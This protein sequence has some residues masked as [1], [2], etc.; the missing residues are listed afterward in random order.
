MNTSAP[1]VAVS[2]GNFPSGSDPTYWTG[3]GVSGGH[4]YIAVSHS[5]DDLLGVEDDLSWHS[6]IGVKSATTLYGFADGE[7]IGS[8]SLTGG[9]GTYLSIGNYMATSNSFE[10][11]GDIAEVIVFNYQLNPSDRTVVQNYLVDK[12]PELDGLPFLINNDDERIN[13]QGGEN[14]EFEN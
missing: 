8:S 10:W 7:S 2:F 14:L 13:T 6:T 5:F 12:Y 1:T 4:S 11:I 9:S 3:C